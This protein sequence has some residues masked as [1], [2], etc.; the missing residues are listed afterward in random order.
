NPIRAAL[1]T[2]SCLK[3]SKFFLFSVA[4]GFLGET[5]QPRFLLL[6]INGKEVGPAGHEATNN[7]L[8]SLSIPLNPSHL[9]A[10]AHRRRVALSFSYV[11]YCSLHSRLLRNI[12]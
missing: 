10:S 3:R 11:V 5:V 9:L 1:K 7:F 6:F 12:S 8:I 2:K 4:F